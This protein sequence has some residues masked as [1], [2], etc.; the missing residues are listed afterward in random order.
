MKNSGI[1]LT[2]EQIF[3]SVWGKD[4][5]EI[6]TVAVHIKSIRNKLD[7]EEKYIKTVWGVGYKFIKEREYDQK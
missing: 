6:S 1:V 5:G 4:Y 7:K 2:K 3:E